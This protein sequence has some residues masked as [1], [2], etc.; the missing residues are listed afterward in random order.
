MRGGLTLCVSWLTAGLP[1]AAERHARG[2][3]RGHAGVSSEPL[4]APVSAPVP[5]VWAL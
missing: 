4:Q 1:L 2:L 5:F 3:Q